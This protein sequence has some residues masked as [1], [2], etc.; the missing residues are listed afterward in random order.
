MTVKR[1]YGRRGVQFAAAI[2]AGIWLAPIAAHAETYT[3]RVDGLACPFCSYGVEKQLLKISGVNDV[4]T[5]IK[6]G[7]LKVGTKK[8]V[9]LTGAQLRAAVQKSG[10]TLRSFK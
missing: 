9:K 1:W 4:K 3:I 2:G 6:T 5:D 7:T 8:G 10:F